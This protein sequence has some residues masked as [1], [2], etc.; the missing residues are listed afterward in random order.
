MGRAK[1]KGRSRD[2][3]GFV[4][5]PH[6]V[7]DSKA[8]L[9]LSASAVR[10]LLDMARQY[11]GQNNG[12]LV[13]CNAYMKTRGWKSND[14]THRA[15]KELIEAGLLV[16]TRIGMRPNRAAWYAL[17]WLTLDWSPEMDMPQTA[18]KRGI[19]AMNDPLPP[20]KPPLQ[21]TRALSRQTG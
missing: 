18:F 14:T 20:L 4:A 6:V 9:S 7:L 3:T 16:E 12:R 1:H 19:Y 11:T 17:T 8:F 15:K 13:A 2:G 10:V 5:L 21:K